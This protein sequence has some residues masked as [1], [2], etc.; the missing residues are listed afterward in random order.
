MR[1]LAWSFAR[2]ANSDGT[3][4]CQQVDVKEP[5]F[6]N[7]RNDPSFSCATTANS[8]RLCQPVVNVSQPVTNASQPAANASQPASAQV[9]AR[10][11][12]CCTGRFQSFYLPWV[13]P[14]KDLIAA[15]TKIEQGCDCKGVLFIG[16]GVHLI[17]TNPTLSGSSASAPW[18][19]PFGRRAGWLQFREDMMLNKSGTL[20]MVL[21]SPTHLDEY[22]LLLHP[23]KPDWKKF[24]QFSTLEM[25]DEMDSRVADEMGVKF[26][27]Y[28]SVTRK[29]KGLQCDGM[30]FGSSYDKMDWNCD[31]FTVVT[32]VAMQHALNLLC[33]KR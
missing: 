22:V 5:R 21:V 27:S 10:L 17:L 4:P 32:D 25:W 19:F 29:F 31:G 3:Q 11:E 16:F 7:T 15:I 12:D 33:P 6:R 20:D 23:P 26:I 1:E 9:K 14:N 24:T 30:H 28:F 8:T 2:L 18:S 13:G